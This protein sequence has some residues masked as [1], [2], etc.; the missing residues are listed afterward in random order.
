MCQDG[1]FGGITVSVTN[2]SAVDLI[3]ARDLSCRVMSDVDCNPSMVHIRTVSCAL[4]E[5]M[6]NSSPTLI[7]V[8]LISSDLFP[9][10]AERSIVGRSSPKDEEDYSEDIPRGNGKHTDFSHWDS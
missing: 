9:H 7:F 8:H 5:W 3:H 10:I 4:I 2:F 6:T 1:G